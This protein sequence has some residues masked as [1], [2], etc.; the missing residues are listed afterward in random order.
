MVGLEELQHMCL[1]ATALPHSKTEKAKRSG[2]QNTKPKRAQEL[3]GNLI[4]GTVASKVSEE[5]ID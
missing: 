5:K 2:E 4:P 1:K 3:Y